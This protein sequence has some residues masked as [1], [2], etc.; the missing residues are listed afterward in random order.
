MAGFVNQ[1]GRRP[2]RGLRPWLLLPKIIAIA[3]ALGG[4]AVVCLLFLTLDATDH[5]VTMA[6]AR[7]VMRVLTW[8]VVPAVVLAVVLGAGL[9]M[10]HGPILLRM[11]WLMVKLIVMIVCIPPLVGVT[12]SQARWLI[13]ADPATNSGYPGAAAGLGAISSGGAVVVW[14][15][16]IVLGRHKPRLGQPVTTV[17]QQ[18][19]MKSTETT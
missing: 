18:R 1:H 15:I 12:L 19:K 11:R 14:A 17:Y 8:L 10:L 16:I 5:A 3:V 4:T 2:G 13:E 6:Q 9:V 7:T